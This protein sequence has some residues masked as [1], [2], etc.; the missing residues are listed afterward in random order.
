MAGLVFVPL[1][2]DTLRTW[3]TTG[4]LAGNVRGYAVTPTMADAFGF[5]DTTDE[6]AEHTALCIASLA[7]LLAGGVRLVGVADTDHL[8]D[9]ADAEFGSVSVSDVPFTRVTALFAGAEPATVEGVAG[10][11]LATA[12]EREDLQELLSRGDPL[13]HGA[14]EWPVLTDGTRA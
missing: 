3:A 13:W 6:D 7:A 11:A 1:N 8:N 14:G 10:M 2:G 9:P 4:V 12:W 5:T